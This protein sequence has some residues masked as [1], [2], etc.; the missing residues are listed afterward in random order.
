MAA[1]VCETSVGALA[2]LLR[3]FEVL[4]RWLMDLR[5]MKKVKE[6]LCLDDSGESKRRK[7][8]KMRHENRMPTPLLRL[9]A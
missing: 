6:F 1:D 3:S 2:R 4:T 9:G 7:S 5:D 8:R